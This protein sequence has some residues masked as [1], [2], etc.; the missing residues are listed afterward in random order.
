MH[1]PPPIQTFFTARA[2]QDGDALAAAFSPDAIVHDEARSHHGP[3]AI[4]DWWLAAKA[5]YRHHAE[6]MDVA[7]AGGKTVVQA[8]VTGD[9]PGSPAVLTFTF[10]LKGERICDLEIG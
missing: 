7:E 3:Q 2:P 9:F 5:K 10:G 4:R 1:L 8:T 6:P